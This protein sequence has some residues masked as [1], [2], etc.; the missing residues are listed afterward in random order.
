MNTEDEE[1]RE[2]WHD[3][4]NTLAMHRDAV[5][6]RKTRLLPPCPFCGAAAMASHFEDEDDVFCSQF[7][8]KLGASSDL[9]FTHD[10]WENMWC[11]KEID[12]LTEQVRKKREY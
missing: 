5:V 4:C 9:M 2:H 11:R 7:K 12:S 1:E 10:E 3:R 8:C 6:E